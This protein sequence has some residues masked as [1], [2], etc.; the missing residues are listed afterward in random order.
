MRCEI[1]ETYYKCGET[2]MDGC[3]YPAF[4]KGRGR[5]KK[6]RPTSRCQ[7]MVNRHHAIGKL[8]RELNAFFT[9]DDVEI[10]L[11]FRPDALP[12]SPEGAMREYR[13]FLRR[14]Q[15]RRAARGLDRALWVLVPA[16]DG[17]VTRLH[18]HLTISGGIDRDELEELWGLGYANSRRLEFGRNGVEGLAVYISRQFSKDDA[19]QLR[20]S[21]NGEVLGGVS[22]YKKAWYASRGIHDVEPRERTG[23]V[24][25][26]KA[27]A[28]A[29]HAPEAVQ[30]LEAL[31]PGYTVSEW[32]A[33]VNSVNGGVYI[34]YKLYRADKLAED[35][36]KAKKR[37]AG[38][39][40]CL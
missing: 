15:R 33:V 16:G 5:H 38:K 14:V 28:I 29:E 31:H 6:A 7:E 37:N 11:T 17:I 39:A 34:E 19:A 25:Q 4:R 22:P 35:F 21:E 10:H 27:K 2:Y 3:L 18:A 32:R 9:R 24:S 40:A 26:K 36:K 8:K 12:S 1:R 13:N 30:L 23:V 20:I